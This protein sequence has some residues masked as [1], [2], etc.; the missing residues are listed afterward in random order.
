MKAVKLSMM[1]YLAS[2]LCLILIFVQPQITR[3]IKQ[4][5]PLEVFLF[6]DTSYSQK[7]HRN[8]FKSYGLEI[9]QEHP[10]FQVTIYDSL[11]QGIPREQF[12]DTFLDR[13]SP[14]SLSSHWLPMVVKNLR[15]KVYSILFSDFLFEDRDPFQTN[16][17]L[18]KIDA[19]TKSPS[20]SVQIDLQKE[21]LIYQETN[22]IDIYLQKKAGTSFPPHL[23]YQFGILD[24][25]PQ[26]YKTV[27]LPPSPLAQSLSLQLFP[28]SGG[29]HFL[30][31]ECG[32]N[33][34]Y[35]DYRIFNIRGKHLKFQLYS[36]IPNY[37]IQ[38]LKRLFNKYQTFSFENENHLRPREFT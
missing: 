29:P 13:V 37:E 27:A 24:S 17:Y 25:P 6:F 34:K 12:K 11:A 2:V 28:Q 8:L 18:Y 19:T 10:D 9:L 35:T 3:E 32:E 22:I 30:K 1:L 15:R 4:K 7:A 23:K 16:A 31:V 5:S 26:E 21:S 36:F 33:K 14:V 20:L 38:A